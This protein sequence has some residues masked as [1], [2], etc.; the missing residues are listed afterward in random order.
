MS[1]AHQIPD[2]DLQMSWDS[3][4]M[5]QLQINEVDSFDQE[6]RPGFLRATPWEVF[7]MKKRS[8]E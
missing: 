8:D 3:D 2:L 6:L 7:S 1:R 5:N 4:L